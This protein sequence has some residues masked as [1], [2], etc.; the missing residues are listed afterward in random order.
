MRQADSVAGSGSAESSD[1][2]PLNAGL[3]EQRIYREPRDPVWLD[4][5]MVTE[6]MIAQFHKE[7]TAIGSRFL[8]L[9]VPNSVEIDPNPIVRSEFAREVGAKDL[10]YVDRRL[11]GL[12]DRLGFATLILSEELGKYSLATGHA[13]C[14]FA[15]TRLGRGHF[16]A[17]GHRIAGESLAT[18]I[19]DLLTQP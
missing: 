19:A 8:V 11:R 7:A 3:D 13:L 4:A 16:N 1:L 12:G 6:A 14:G 15:N 2:L 18:A 5:W 10:S 9:V 17:E